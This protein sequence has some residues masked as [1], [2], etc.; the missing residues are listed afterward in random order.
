[1]ISNSF[2]IR[3]GGSAVVVVEVKDENLKDAYISF[4]DEKRFELIPYKKEN[5]YIS[6]IAWP[7]TKEEFSKG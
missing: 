4:N 2:H 3:Q 5:F 6:L 7:V 1:M